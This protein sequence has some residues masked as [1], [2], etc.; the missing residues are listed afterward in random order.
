M[1]H[2]S[3]EMQACINACTSCHQVCLSTALGHCLEMGG[4]HVEKAHFTLMMAMRRDLSN[5]GNPH[6]HR[7]APPQTDVS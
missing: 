4:E 5:V 2:L 6:A 1:H 7:V 3:S